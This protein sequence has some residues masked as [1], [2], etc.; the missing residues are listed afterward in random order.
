MARKPA[1][2]AKKSVDDIFDDAAPVQAT[3]QELKA[4]SVLVAKALALEAEIEA[5]SG[6][7]AELKREHAAITELTLPEALDTANCSEFK[8][9][10]SGKKVTLKERVNASISVANAPQAHA[11]LRKN[12]HGDLIKN[13][14]VVQIERGKDNIVGKLIDD[15][16]KKYGIDSERKESVHAQTLGAFCRE[17]LAAGAELPAALLGL[18]V[19]RVANIK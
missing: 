16:K 15:I 10:D 3:A 5:M 8:D 9:S 14:L 11:W 6:Q 4:I 1:A 17:Q 13:Q 19:Q 7:L 2:K 18:H 12:G